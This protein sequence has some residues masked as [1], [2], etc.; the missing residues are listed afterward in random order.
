[1]NV[2]KK[3]ERI[4]GHGGYLREFNERNACLLQFTAS[5]SKIDLNNNRILKLNKCLRDM[6]KKKLI[7]ENYKKI[8]KS[9]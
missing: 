6:E 2:L 9:G 3:K 4:A 5:R 8:K 1:M 7:I